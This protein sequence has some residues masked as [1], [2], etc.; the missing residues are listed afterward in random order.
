MHSTNLSLALPWCC[1]RTH[2][3]FIS[4]KFISRNSIA[5]LMLPPSPS[6]S[7]PVSGKRPRDTCRP[8]SSCRLF[9]WNRILLASPQHILANVVTWS[10]FYIEISPC[11]SLLLRSMSLKQS[12]PFLFSAVLFILHRAGSTLSHIGDKTGI[13]SCSKHPHIYPRKHI[14][15]NSRQQMSPVIGNSS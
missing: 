8:R 7:D 2:N 1:I 13:I 3:L 12:R 9:E 14:R 10:W 4:V 5:S 15:F 11:H 6:N